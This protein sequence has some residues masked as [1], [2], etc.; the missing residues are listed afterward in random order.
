M[1]SYSDA[2]ILLTAHLMLLPYRLLNAMMSS[3]RSVGLSNG[4]TLYT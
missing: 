3:I 1:H 2:V 4:T